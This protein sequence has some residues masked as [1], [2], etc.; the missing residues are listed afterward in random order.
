MGHP[1]ARILLPQGPAT[2]NP[3]P[4]HCPGLSP[5]LQ[6]RPL[7]KF[8]SA[9]LGFIPGAARTGR[10]HLLQALPLFSSCCSRCA[11]PSSLHPIPRL[12]QLESL[13]KS[14]FGVAIKRCSQAQLALHFCT[15]FLPNSCI[16]SIWEKETMGLR[17]MQLERCRLE[18]PHSGAV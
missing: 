3:R 2:W 17:E 6:P 9:S 11:N 8:H 10:W 13:R 12:G 7:L 16:L 15:D 14:P 18:V 1:H 4:A 5:S